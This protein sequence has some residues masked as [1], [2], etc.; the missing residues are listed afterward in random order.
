MSAP[1]SHLVPA[2]KLRLLTRKEQRY[3]AARLR[4]ET[5]IESAR[6]AGL[7]T[8]MAKTR[9]MPEVEALVD[10]ATQALAEVRF[11]QCLIDATEI[12]EYLTDA[13][14][15]RMSDI[16]NDDHT[17]KPRSQWPDIWDRLE[18]AGDVEVE[19]ESVRSHDGEDTE[20]R[21]GWETGGVVR[22][23][24]FKF[25]SRTKLL[26]LAMKHKGVDAMVQQKAGGDVHLHLHAE[27]TSRLQGALAR[28]QRIIDACGGP[29]SSSED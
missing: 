4:G 22:K 26:E 18:E 7:P 17:F 3:V 23:V 6:F 8:W 9:N 10:E 24:K 15:A 12:H 13:I 1:D 19:Y 11:E 28:E 27:I 16:R 29:E 14:R 21:G 5:Q 20:G 25:A 2:G